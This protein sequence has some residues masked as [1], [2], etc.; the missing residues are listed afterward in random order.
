[1]ESE[2]KVLYYEQCGGKQTFWRKL[3]REMMMLKLDEAVLLL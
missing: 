2:K 3:K 1:M